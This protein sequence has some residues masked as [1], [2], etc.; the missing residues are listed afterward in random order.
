LDQ[1][2]E[3]LQKTIEMDS[4]FPISHLFLAMAYRNKGRYD[5]AFR[6]LEKVE[7]LPEGRTIFLAVLGY[8]YATSGRTADARKMLVRLKAQ[9]AT[10]FELA[11][12]H[13]GLGEKDQVFE[14]LEKAYIKRDPFLLFLKV[15]PNFDSLRT[16]P[17][18][19][20]LLQRLNLA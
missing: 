9:K 10:D 11:L 19:K 17:R 8:C 16:D 7:K 14:W 5:D 15:D 13:V 1:S 2:I 6:V 3:Q 12:V 18:F 20:D 4:N